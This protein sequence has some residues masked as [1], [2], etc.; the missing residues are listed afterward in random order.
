VRGAPAIG[1]AAAMALVVAVQAA[2]A[3]VRG[4]Q[5]GVAL[6][7]ARRLRATRPTAVN[8]A[9]AL[10]RMLAVFD[11]AEPREDVVASLRR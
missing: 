1:I 2:G 7:A 11:G 9:W 4:T 10:D 3:A 5:R 6:D 8:L